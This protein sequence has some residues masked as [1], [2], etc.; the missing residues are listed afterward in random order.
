MATTISTDVTLAPLT[1]RA[2]TLEE[3]LTTFHMAV[4][5]LDPFTQEGAWIL[6]IATRVLTH[7]SQADVRV[8]LLLPATPDE[9][10][11]FLGPWVNTLLTFADPEREAI[12]GMGF[13]KLPAFAHIA[14]DGTVEGKAEGWFP[15]EWQKV[16]DHLAEVMSWS[17]TVVERDGDP[18]PFPAR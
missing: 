16:V 9:C 15:E 14:M 5:A 17:S 3:F 13:D 11:L 1:G 4:V 7:F 8:A 2:R 18:A 6:P 10:R 12:R